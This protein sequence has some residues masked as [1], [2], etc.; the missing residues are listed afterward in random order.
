MIRIQDEILLMDVPGGSRRNWLDFVGDP[1]C[2]GDSGF[3]TI[4]KANE[5]QHAMYEV[6]VAIYQ[7]ISDK[8][9]QWVCR[10]KFWSPS[11]S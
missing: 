10:V 7:Q 11:N 4:S 8:S 9:L 5:V 2:F 3:F 1:E 6:T